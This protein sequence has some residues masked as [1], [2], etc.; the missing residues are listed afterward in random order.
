[1]KLKLIHIPPPI[2]D[3][4]RRVLHRWRRFHTRTKLEDLKEGLSLAKRPDIIEKIEQQLN[5]PEPSEETPSEEPVNSFL[6]PDLLPYLKDVE[7]FDELRVSG[8]L[9]C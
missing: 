6:E 7:R 4:A 8:K 5:P 3:T 9:W 1:M 2:Q